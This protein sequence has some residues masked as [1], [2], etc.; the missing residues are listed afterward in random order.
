MLCAASSEA[1]PLDIQRAVK[2]AEDV[3]V[4]VDFEQIRD[5]VVTVEE[6]P[7]VPRGREVPLAGFRELPENLTALVDALD[8]RQGR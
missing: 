1:E 5:S 4:A 6:N 2:H 3:H 8:G 7:Y